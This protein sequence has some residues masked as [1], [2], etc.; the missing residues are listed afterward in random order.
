MGMDAPAT[1]KL[2]ADRETRAAPMATGRAILLALIL[3]PINAFWVVK[4]E[5]TRYAGHPTTISLF[6]NVIFWLTLL[7]GLNAVV[8]RFTPRFAFAPGELLTVYLMLA[9]SSALAGHDTIEVLT[10]ILAHADHFADNANDWATRVFPYLPSFL[11]VS[12]KPALKEFYQGTGTLYTAHNLSAWMI[13]VLCWTGFL[14]LLS[15]LMLCMN[16]ILR[17]QWTVSEKLAYPLV[18][19]PLEMV[20]PRTALFRDRIF[21]IGVLLSA[22]MEAWNGLAFLYPSMPMLP[23]RMAD[24]GQDL[25]GFLP[26]PWKAIG[27]TPLTLYPFGVALGMLLPVDLLF[28]S[29]FFSWVWR[30]ERVVGVV[31]S[32]DA[33]PDFPYVESQALG[34]FLGI[35][36]FAL[37]NGRRHFGRIF[38]ALFDRSI[39]LED[40]A[41]PLPYRV[42]AWG[43]LLGTIALFGFCRLCGMG[44]GVIAAFFGL[45]FLIAVAITRMR[46]EL[47]PPAHDLHMSGPDTMLPKLADPHSFSRP[48]LAMFSLFYGFNRAYRG[49]PMPIQLEGFKMAEQSGGSYRSL[50]GAMLLAT[51]F[52]ALCGFWANLDQGYRFGAG[53]RIGPPNVMLI[54]GSEPW[55]RYNGWMAQGPRPQEQFHHNMAVLVGFAFTLLLNALRLR[56]AG[57]PFHP[58]GYAISSSWSLGLLWLPLLIAWAIKSLLLKY[59]GL[60]AYRRALPLFLGLILGECIL[61]S[62]WTLIGISLDIPTYSFWP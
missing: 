23:L 22:V 12:D 32:F 30:A 28:S 3:M 31:Y 37:W 9:L 16:V 7:I 55:N 54:F 26:H 50:V 35:G 36:A 14:T 6:F 4:M 47:G 29:W 58:V 27:W 8:R 11:H 10:P 59:G 43:L 18:T 42:A 57:F 49:H 45:Y 33:M 53:A 44:Y 61:G 2:I 5:V 13:P 38:D 15:L 56:F 20:N 25:S 41:E 19:L 40:A 60:R 51:I 24:G 46:A 39:N 52:G 1:K 62:L 21:W 48:E 17:R 34:A